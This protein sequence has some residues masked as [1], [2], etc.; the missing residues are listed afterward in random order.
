[1]NCNICQSAVIP[2]ITTVVMLL[3]ILSVFKNELNSSRVKD[4]SISLNPE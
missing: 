1:M 2:V 3:S 4:W